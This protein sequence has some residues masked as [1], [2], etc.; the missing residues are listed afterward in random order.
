MT[1]SS[2]L[3]PAATPAV[4]PSEAS[5]GAPSGRPSTAALPSGPWCL[6]GLTQ[7]TAS[8]RWVAPANVGTPTTFWR[9]VLCGWL[10]YAADAVSKH[11]RGCR[12]RAELTPLC[13]TQVVGRPLKVYV[14]IMHLLYCNCAFKYATNTLIFWVHAPFLCRHPLLRTP[15]EHADFPG[16]ARV[17]QW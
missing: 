5:L 1:P 16:H 9:A 11:K 2:A 12:T 4:T 17:V 14:C 3:R 13:R 15:V 8:H 7:Q 6:T 10:C